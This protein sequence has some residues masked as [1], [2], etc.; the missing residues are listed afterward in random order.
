MEKVRAIVML[1][2]HLGRGKGRELVR[3]KKETLAFSSVQMVGKRAKNSERKR[4]SS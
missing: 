2:R 3:H 4:A 1:S